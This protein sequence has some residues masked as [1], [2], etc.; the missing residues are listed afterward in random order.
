MC[1]SSIRQCT[2]N[3]MLLSHSPKIFKFLTAQLY[4]YIVQ[5]NHMRVVTCYFNACIFSDMIKRIKIRKL[6]PYIIG[7]KSTGL[8]DKILKRRPPIRTTVGLDTI[9]NTNCPQAP[10][11]CCFLFIFQCIFYFVHNM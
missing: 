1:Y 3:N 2:N 8:S 6:S 11:F 9:K 4:G 5:H 10:V 7:V